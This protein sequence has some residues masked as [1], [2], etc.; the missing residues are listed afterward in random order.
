MF[1]ILKST[2]NLNYESDKESKMLW[3]ICNLFFRL[4]KIF[5]RGKFGS[6]E[7]CVVQ[8]NCIDNIF[9]F[10]G[11]NGCE[12]SPSLQVNHLK[13]NNASNEGNDSI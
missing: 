6:N 7:H 9:F 4:T 12:S 13:L 5:N 2:N 10:G 1:L 8:D 3:V 11:R